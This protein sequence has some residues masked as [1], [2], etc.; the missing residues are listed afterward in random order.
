MMNDS[1]DK[2]TPRFEAYT[3]ILR[4]SD[5][6]FYTGWTND[7][8]KRLRAHNRGIG[9]RYTRSR[10]PVELVWFL[11]APSKEE[12]MRREAQIKKLSRREKLRLISG[13]SLEEIF[14]EK[15]SG[16]PKSQLHHKDSPL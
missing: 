2:K 7:L 12:A 9:S 6:T 14:R 3:Y 10:L 11:P 4:C 16:A 8:K 13:A 5:D 15:E 1:Q